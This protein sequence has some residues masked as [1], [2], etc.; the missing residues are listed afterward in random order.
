MKPSSLQRPSIRNFPRSVVLSSLIAL[1]SIATREASKLYFF[2]VLGEIPLRSLSYT[3]LWV[4]LSVVFSTITG[5]LLD[6]FSKKK[7]L[8][9]TMLM[10]LISIM[11]LDLGC[12]ILGIVINGV[13]CNVT[14]VGRATYSYIHAQRPSVR[15]FAETFA[16][17]ALPWIVICLY[18]FIYIHY[19][20]S[21]AIAMSIIALIGSACFLY[22]RPQPHSNVPL[23]FYEKLQ[24]IRGDR[25]RIF[26]AFFFS[27]IAYQLI[28]YYL[29][30]HFVETVVSNSF[31]LLGMGIFIGAIFHWAVHFT[32]GIKEIFV[33]YI[34]SLGVFV[35]GY[36]SYGYFA[37]SALEN[38]SY[39]L[40][41]AI[42]GG[43][44]LPLIFAGFT[45]H[46]HPKEKSFLVGGLES[47]MAMADCLGPVLASFN[48]FTFPT[49]IVL[50]GISTLCTYKTAFYR[51]AV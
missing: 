24:M 27:E 44:G 3:T 8:I 51:K 11:C 30:S 25:F 36:I 33:A 14:V 40:P 46:V 5:Y 13:F 16:V 47:L 49:M 48:I 39:Y 26:V 28:E 42:V 21:I 31:A 17:Q 43:F 45:R 7:I 9:L 19:V 38:F 32:P 10:S 50:L 22:V 15:V 20:K 37:S 29:D 6:R 18:S 12:L 35:S 1:F 41:F 4:G 34:A 23:F 2:L